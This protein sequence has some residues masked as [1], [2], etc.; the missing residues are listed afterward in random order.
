MDDISFEF[1]ALH[2]ESPDKNQFAY[3]LVGYDDYWR[4]TSSDSRHATYTNLESGNYTFVVKS[5]NGDA[6]WDITPAKINVVIKESPW[7]TRWALY[8]YINLFLLAAIIICRYFQLLARRNNQ[9]KR[10]RELRVQQ[11]SNARLQ[12]QFFANVT[13]EFRTP[14]ALITGPINYLKNHISDLDAD[15]KSEQFRVIHKNSTYLQH[16]IDDFLHFDSLESGNANLS[17]EYG[18]V[19]VEIK[20][21]FDKFKILAEEKGILY[22]SLFEKK[23]IY[24]WYD[25]LAI[26]KILSNVISNAIKYENRNGKVFVNIYSTISH[27]E[28]ASIDSELPTLVIKVKDTGIGIPEDKKEKIFERFY[29]G[30]LSK[31]QSSGFGIGLAYVKYLLEVLNGSIRVWSKEG[32]GTVFTIRIPLVK[33]ED[34]IQDNLGHIIHQVEKEANLITN[35]VKIEDGLGAPIPTGNKRPVLLVV[36]DNE[37]MRRFLKV[38]LQDTYDILESEGGLKA[39]EVIAESQV[40]MIL[41]DLRM[42]DMDGF[43]LCRE[44]KK[45]ETMDEVPF[46]ILTGDTQFESEITALK[47]GVDD[48]FSKPLNLDILKLK[49]YNILLQRRNLRARFV[50]EILIQPTQEDHKSRDLELVEKAVDIVEKNLMNPEFNVLYLVKELSVSRSGLHGRLKDVTGLSTSKFIRDIRLKRAAHLLE[51]TDFSIKEIMFMS[52]FN[53]SSYFAKCFKGKY[54]MIPS[55]YAGEKIRDS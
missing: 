1:V 27:D 12:S 54:G 3:K 7:L 28:E 51:T 4:Y 32:E 21:V 15:A 34:L 40:D 41:S 17:F 8:G 37:D 30:D 45:M 36:D 20:N 19:C 38:G 55:D 26:D 5:S 29:R 6:L 16:L 46:F 13:H 39:I 44:V 23:E 10:E 22:Q 14:L 42:P 25:K 50:R 11:E 43:D 2:F 18:D 24:G 47:V 33:R 35:N 52:G 53:S 48:Y 31:S 49:M 9:L